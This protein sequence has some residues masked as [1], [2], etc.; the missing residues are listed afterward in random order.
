MVAEAAFFL[1]LTLQMD[2]VHLAPMTCSGLIGSRSLRMAGDDA[3]K[4]RPY[5]FSAAAHLTA[6]VAQHQGRKIFDFNRARDTQAQA[7]ARALGAVRARGC[8]GRLQ[9]AAVLMP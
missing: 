9:G 3:M 4:I 6:Q 7:F 5:G 1:K 8:A 2:A